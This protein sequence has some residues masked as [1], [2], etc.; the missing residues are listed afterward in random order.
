M[1]P[2]LRPRFEH[3]KQTTKGKTL[4]EGLKAALDQLK[5]LLGDAMSRAG[6]IDAKLEEF[7]KECYDAGFLEG[8]K[9]VAVDE[10]IFSQKDLD[11]KMAPL[12][13]EIAKLKLEIEGVPAKIEASKVEALESFKAEF[14]AKYAEAQ[15]AEGEVEKLFGDLLA[16]KVI[17]E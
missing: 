4:M 10:K 17:A 1:A 11:E 8:V 3:I 6:D 5:I 14:S 9:S 12:N 2:I 13:E 16:P 7:K 15:K